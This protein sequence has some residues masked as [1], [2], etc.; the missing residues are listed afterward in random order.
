VCCGRD[1]PFKY[2]A[3]HDNEQLHN[4][5][6]VINE[7]TAEENGNCHVY[8]LKVATLNAAATCTQHSELHMILQGKMKR[9]LN[10][11]LS[12]SELSS[13]MYCRVK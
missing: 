9:I 12:C 5:E 8:F 6:M 4:L 2:D 3:R 7:E 10:I 1:L 13:G 11:R